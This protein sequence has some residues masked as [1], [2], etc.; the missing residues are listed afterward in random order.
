MAEYIIDLR[1]ETPLKSVSIYIKNIYNTDIELSI[2]LL[3]M[4][5]F[6]HFVVK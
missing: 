6:W 3:V 1:E 5:W 4:L 2:M